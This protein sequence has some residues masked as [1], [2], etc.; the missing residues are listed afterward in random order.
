MTQNG[1]TYAIPSSQFHR[2]CLVGRGMN[3]RGV[4][5]VSVTFAIAAIAA[6]CGGSATKTASTQ[7]GAPQDYY[8]RLDAVLRTSGDAFNAGSGGATN[9]AGA[10]QASIDILAR[11]E[12]SLVGLSPPAEARDAHRE[13]LGATG[14]LR[15]LAEK[16]RDAPAS[17][18]VTE[19]EVVPIIGRFFAACSQLSGAA[20]RAASLTLTCASQ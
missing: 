5:V 3:A 6:A 19:S 7:V 2:S 17:D 1:A 12:G 20:Q 10:I 15:R 14:D 11:M 9:G 4:A 18:S 16:R 13:L 8:H